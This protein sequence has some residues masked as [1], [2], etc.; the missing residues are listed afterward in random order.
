ME[1]KKECNHE[2]YETPDLRSKCK[3]CNILEE[4]VITKLKDSWSREEV[5]ELFHK[6]RLARMSNSESSMN[7]FLTNNL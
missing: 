7:E 6:C 4:A 2:F 5:I 3:F 1:V